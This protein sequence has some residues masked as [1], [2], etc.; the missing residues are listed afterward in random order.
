MNKELMKLIREK[1]SKLEERKKI[2]DAILEKRDSLTVK[3]LDSEQEKLNS[4]K[5][6][7]RSI[8]EKINNLESQTDTNVEN[9]TNNVNHRSINTNIPH[10]IIE[11]AKRTQEEVLNST[12]YRN[13]FYR[14]VMNNKILKTDYD[15]MQEGKR[16]I[17]D[18]NGGTVTSGAEYLVP[19]TTLNMIKEII[20]VWGNIYALVEKTSFTG[21][22]SLPIA[23]EGATTDNG[24]G[25][26]T[27]TA[28]FTEVTINQMA[29]IAMIKV[30]NL[31]LKNSISAFENYLT[32]QLGKYLGKQLTNYVLNGSPTTSKFTGIIFKI[33][34]NAE[35]TTYSDIDWAWINSVQGSLES[36][37]G[38]NAVWVMKR[39]TFFTKFRSL[40]DANGKPLAEIVTGGP[41]GSKYYIA[42]Q[43]CF[44]TTLMPTGD[45]DPILY[46]DLK[47]YMVNESEG[48][49]IESSSENDTAFQADETHWR[50]KV[51]SGGKPT[52]PTANTFKYFTYE[53][54]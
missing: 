44:F 16:V 26:V 30:K 51:Y 53:A 19:T 52:L 22:V 5:D 12:E 43:E 9:N 54:A 20:E 11:P 8:E 46:G 27:L 39:S 23:T 3:E 36:P 41:G 37:Y 14:S 33:K 24:D 48:I 45:T 7:I 40:V 13:A 47:T 38:D 18:M 28:T 2:Q 4:L 31:L 49:S 42:G 25:S 34:D 32:K 17:T 10:G 35:N 50:G 21:N 15:I 6:E 1:A 29:V